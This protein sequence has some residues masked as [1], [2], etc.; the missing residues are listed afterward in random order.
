MRQLP[1]QEEQQQGKA[2]QLRRRRPPREE[3]PLL[4]PRSV[5]PMPGPTESECGLCP[6][7]IMG[8]LVSNNYIMVEAKCIIR[9]LYSQKDALKGLKATLIQIEGTSRQFHFEQLC[10]GLL[11]HVHHYSSLFGTSKSLLPPLLSLPSYHH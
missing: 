7:G 8:V 10:I 11:Y 2:I 5:L 1:E 4:G 9:S 6:E 3:W